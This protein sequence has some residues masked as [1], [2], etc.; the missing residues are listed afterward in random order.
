MSKS[1]M[2]YLITFAIAC[3]FWVITGLVLAGHLSDTV[4]LATLA[5]EDFLFWYRIA[6]TAVGVI[7]LLLTYY[8]YVYGSKDSTA[9]DLEQARRVWYQLFVILI[10][11]AIV[12]LFAKVIIFLD[13]GIAI[14]DYLI[15]F[16]ALSLHT[17]IFY[18]LCTFLMSPRAVKYL[19]PLKK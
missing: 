13:E 7:S 18:W 5:I 8:W 2:N 6:I 16:A 11:V 14:I 1:P 15:I 19:V 4:S 10:I 3:L 12:A 17:Y 9:G